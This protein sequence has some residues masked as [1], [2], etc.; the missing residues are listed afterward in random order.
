ME[1]A[2][3]ELDSASRRARWN[4]QRGREQHGLAPSMGLKTA[5]RP[6]HRGDSRRHGLCRSG[7]DR[8]A[9]ARVC[10]QWQ[11]EK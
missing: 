3:Q 2:R 9:P 8:P 11:S 10:F 1:K 5:A 4:S 6:S 7:G